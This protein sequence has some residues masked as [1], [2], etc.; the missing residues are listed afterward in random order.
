[1]NVLVS[2]PFHADRLG[3]E[4]STPS[5]NCDPDQ[6]V[7]YCHGCG[8]KGKISKNPHLLPLI[9]EVLS[10]ETPR[11]ISPSVF[12][13]ESLPEVPILSGASKKFLEDR[14]FN[15]YVLRTFDI[16]GDEEKI[17]IPIK[18]RSGAVRGYIFRNLYTLPKY[19]FSYHFKRNHYLFGTYQFVKGIDGVFVVEGPLDCMRMHQLGHPNTVAIMGSHLSSEQIELLKLLG[20][21]I[22]LVFDNDEAGREA[23]TKAG[24]AIAEAGLKPSVLVYE[25]KD[26]GELESDDSWKI[27][28]YLTHLLHVLNISGNP[29]KI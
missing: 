17:W 18:V 26:P 20:T 5:C 21:D 10:G 16:G 3:S 14:G 11:S 6:D 23:T 25:G 15:S 22:C 29:V 9:N 8:A 7:F 2:C 27:E 4:D 19:V 13:P 12:R 28:P 24:K 1:M